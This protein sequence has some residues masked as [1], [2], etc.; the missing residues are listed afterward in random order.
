[1]KCATARQ[2]VGS[3]SPPGEALRCSQGVGDHWQGAAG[4]CM[5]IMN[6]LQYPGRASRRDP[7]VAVSSDRA[8]RA[9]PAS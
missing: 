9:D 8:A 2:E 5:S 4:Q 7:I 6:M 3:G 1:M